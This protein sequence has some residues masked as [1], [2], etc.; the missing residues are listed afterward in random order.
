[1]APGSLTIGGVDRNYGGGTNWN[2]NTAGLLLETLDNT[3]IAIHYSN[4][5]LASFMY[6][7]SANNRFTIGRDMG[8]GAIS[9]VNIQG[10]LQVNGNLKVTG[11]VDSQN[12]RIQVTADDTINIDTDTWSD[13]PQ[14]I[15][16]AN[17]D[18][19]V[20]VLF[21]AGGVQAYPGNN[22]RAYFRLLIDGNQKAL[23]TQEFHNR[24]WELRDASLMWLESSLAVGN[25]VFKVQW[26]R[27]EPGR[28]TACW[29]RDL[30]SLIVVNL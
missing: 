6:Y 9:A 15:V 16:T 12:A 26:R 20:L 29:Y 19:P 11:K 13:M 14:M 23:A 25:H 5:R 2:S 28:V 10:N 30:R 7:E 18:G 3:E 8:S 17:I 21:K 1:M 24:G 4:S 27:A 22:V